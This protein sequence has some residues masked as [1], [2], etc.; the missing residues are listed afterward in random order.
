MLE[1]VERG[2]D[3][4]VLIFPPN[5]YWSLVKS[6]KW[7][8]HK[9]RR[10]TFQGH[11]VFLLNLET[12][13]L[14]NAKMWFTRPFIM[15]VFTNHSSQQQQK[16]KVF[17]SIISMLEVSRSILLLFKNCEE[18]HHL[19]QELQ[20][21]SDNEK[22][23][24]SNHRWEKDILRGPCHVVFSFHIVKVFHVKISLILE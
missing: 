20:F 18:F 21:K 17:T 2:V 8:Q 4:H 16:I 1:F 11:G 24:F 5:W 19:I 3:C 10:W 7:F 9:K 6:S 15:L 13:N 14:K 12:S 23:R 22:W